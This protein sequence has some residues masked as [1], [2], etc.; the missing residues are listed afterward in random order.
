M[1]PKTV[2][3][4]TM[5]VFYFIKKFESLKTKNVTQAIDFSIPTAN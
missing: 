4:E 3:T 1:L 2:K 5:R